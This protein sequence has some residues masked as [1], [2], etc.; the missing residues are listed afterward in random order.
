MLWKRLFVADLLLGAFLTWTTW[1]AEGW[2]QPGENHTMLSVG[3]RHAWRRGR[4]WTLYTHRRL[5]ACHGSMGCIVEQT[6]LSLV[7]FTLIFRRDG[8]ANEP[9]EETCDYTDWDCWLQ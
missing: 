3:I 2:R 9:P 7:D 5:K 8:I 1:W 4:G 6:K